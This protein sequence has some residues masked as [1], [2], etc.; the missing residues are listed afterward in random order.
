MHLAQPALTSEYSRILQFERLLHCSV[1]S[2]FAIEAGLWVCVAHYWHCA[3][4]YIGQPEAL[5]V[6]L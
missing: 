6:S 1:H 4:K 5:V 2:L 3:Y